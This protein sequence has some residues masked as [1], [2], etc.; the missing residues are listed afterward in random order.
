MDSVK[1]NDMSCKDLTYTIS[2]IIKSN[3][4]MKNDYGII[5]KNCKFCSETFSN[6]I[7]LNMHLIKHHKNLCKICNV[8]YHIF[9]KG[10]C[11]KTH[12]CQIQASEKKKSPQ[13]IKKKNLLHDLIKSKVTKIKS[14][15]LNKILY[16]NDVSFIIKMKLINKFLNQ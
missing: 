6:K 10:S 3:K 2:T 15:T 7:G 4:P 12:I 5:K 11:F 8:C 1:S 14:E 13:V 9:P 16:D